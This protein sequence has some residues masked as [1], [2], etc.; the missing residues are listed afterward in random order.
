MT[1]YSTRY[2]LISAMILLAMP[3]YSQDVWPG[4]V[5]N[6]GIV[7]G[8]DLLYLGIAYGS[9]GPTRAEEDTNWEP[10]PI[11][12]AWGQSFP[13]GLNYA[14]ADCNG[15]GVVDDNDIEEAIKDNFGETHSPI[16]SGEYQNGISG[17]NAPLKMTPSIGMNGPNIVITIALELGNAAFPIN[18]FYGIALKLSYDAGLID[19][20]DFEFGLTADSWIDTPDGLNTAVLFEDDDDQ[21]KAEV[22]ITLTDPVQSRSGFGKIGE[23]SIIMEDIIVGL[24]RDTFHIQIDSVLLISPTIKTTPIVTDSIAFIISEDLKLLSDLQGIA[25]APKVNVFPNPNR[26]F[27]Y[28][29][30]NESI[31]N[32]RVFNLLGQMVPIQTNLLNARTTFID[33]TALKSGTYLITGLT[34]SGEFRKKVMVMN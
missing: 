18:D 27:F 22:A 17:V 34:A 23:F 15:D 31:E 13:N 12:S 29:S 33:L 6:N 28:I 14:Y 1:F 4:D 11:V 30:A 16:V 5:N 24:T 8:V 10:Q 2:L 7:N 21:G 20:A 26:G 25:K 32:I 19:P 3:V 9:T